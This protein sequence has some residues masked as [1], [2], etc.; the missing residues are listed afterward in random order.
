MGTRL[1]LHAELLDLAPRAYYQPPAS[2]RMTYPCF[3]YE[4]ADVDTL[5]ADNRAYRNL[6]CYSIIYIS[7]EPAEEKV[8]EILDHF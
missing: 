4:L 5:Y 2:I 3:R 7:K 1:E 6:L 8:K